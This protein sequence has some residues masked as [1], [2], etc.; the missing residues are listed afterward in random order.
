MTGQSYF[1]DGMAI[2]KGEYD[3]WVYITQHTDTRHDNEEH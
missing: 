3:W 1:S 2:V